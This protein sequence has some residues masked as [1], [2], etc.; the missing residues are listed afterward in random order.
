MRDLNPAFALL[1]LLALP[2]DISV[3]LNTDPTAMEE[4]V[5]PGGTLPPQLTTAIPGQSEVPPPEEV[6]IPMDS[7]S[8]VPL[9]NG[10]VPLPDPQTQMAPNPPIVPVPPHVPLPEEQRAPSGVFVAMSLAVSMMSL[11]SLIIVQIVA[12]AA[13]IGLPVPLLAILPAAS[14]TVFSLQVVKIAGRAETY[15]VT[16]PLTDICRFFGWVLPTSS[17]N[18]LIASLAALILVALLRL[19]ALQ[20]QRAENARASQGHLSLQ[21]SPHGLT[22]GAWELRAF[23]LVVF[24]LSTTATELIVGEQANYVPVLGPAFGIIVLF[25]LGHIILNALKF[26][27]DV[28]EDR[29][30]VRARL[31][32]TA[33]GGEVFVD[34]VCDQLRALPSRPPNPGCSSLFRDWLTTPGWSVAPIVALVHKIEHQ[35]LPAAHTDDDMEQGMMEGMWCSSLDASKNVDREHDTE[36]RTGLEVRPLLESQSFRDDATDAGDAVRLAEMAKARS[37]ASGEAPKLRPQV[38]FDRS[39]SVAL[40]HPVK[41]TTTATYDLRAQS[42]VAGVVCIPWIDCAVPAAALRRIEELCGDITFQV[43]PG[44]LC[45]PHTGGRFAACFDWGT[46][47]PFRWPAEGMLKAALGV[48]IVLPLSHDE[49]QPGMDES[50]RSPMTILMSVAVTCCLGAF[51]YGVYRISPYTHTYDN[52]ALLSSWITATLALF[53]HSFGVSNPGL[54][55]VATLGIALM[56]C[57]TCAVTL[58]ASVALAGIMLGRLEAQG[59]QDRLLPSTIDGWNCGA[60]STDSDGPGV[61]G[62]ISD[63][64]SASSSNAVEV[65]LPGPRPAFAIL[66]PGLA[67]VTVAHMQLLPGR[68]G[69]ADTVVPSS[70]PGDRARLPVPPGLLFPSARGGSRLSSTIPPVAALLAPGRP[71]RLVF[72]DPALN[73]DVEWREVVKTFYGSQ[74][75]QLAD[76]TERL[77]EANTEH[78]LIVVE[79]LPAFAAELMDDNQAPPSSRN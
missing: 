33:G 50:A 17:S 42:L 9:P 18:M 19:V 56:L 24:P 46:R 62:Q 72:E 35:G 31:P 61:C 51:A 65:I 45:G 30:V 14:A 40:A 66:L 4:A 68:S 79:V 74:G 5:K 63:S 71:G 60:R 32:R 47:Y 75:T 57:I 8:E 43:H 48:W 55:W 76:E 58:L 3:E 13:M 69:D 10:E 20:R 70:T 22:S 6:P 54:A 73:E 77:I 12:A 64:H 16:T 34:R 59:L 37:E 44:Q 29:D 49:Y 53:V 28:I 21:S 23:G 26:V 39:S 7:S 41:A 38:T 11:L 25:C 67:R 1:E 15:K 36:V 52:V 2:G 27:T 78:D